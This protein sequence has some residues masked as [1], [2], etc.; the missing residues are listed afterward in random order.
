MDDEQRL[1]E[2]KALAQRIAAAEMNEHV[3]LLR[4]FY[5]ITQAAVAMALTPPRPKTTHKES[6]R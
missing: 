4:A 6:L 5:M 3:D 2:I 1:L